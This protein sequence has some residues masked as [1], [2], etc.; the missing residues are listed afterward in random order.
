MTPLKLGHVH[1]KVSEL[2]RSAKFYASV[3]GLH[4]E[5]RLEGFAFLSDGHVHHSIALQELG[6][7]PVRPQPHAIGLYH[8]AFEVESDDAFREFEDH[9]TGMGIRFQSVDH[10]ISWAAY[11]SDPDGNGLEVYVDRRHAADGAGA[12]TGTSRRLA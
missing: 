11:F 1:L 7:F 2:D 9:L 10:G 6:P 5:E 4:V 3:F 8:V 12:W